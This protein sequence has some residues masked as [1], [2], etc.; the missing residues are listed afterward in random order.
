MCGSSTHICKQRGLK[1][2][3]VTRVHVVIFELGSRDHKSLGEQPVRAINHDAT[4]PKPA[5]NL[6]SPCR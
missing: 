2:K 3:N 6:D 5:I 4:L 1:V